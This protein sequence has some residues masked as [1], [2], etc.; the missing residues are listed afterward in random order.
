MTRGIL[1][2]ET[3]IIYKHR[4]KK[5]WINTTH[6]Y[7]LVQTTAVL[8]PEK[9]MSG[10]VLPQCEYLG[11]FQISHSNV[12]FAYSPILAEWRRRQRNHVAHNHRLRSH[13]MQDAQETWSFHRKQ[14]YCQEVDFTHLV[15]QLPPTASLGWLR[16][17]LWLPLRVLEL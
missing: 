14:K 4:K 1:V 3:Q 8:N 10:S 13:C 15:L 11:H 7:F 16:G 17:R 5:P 2:M 12:C 6:W 9:N